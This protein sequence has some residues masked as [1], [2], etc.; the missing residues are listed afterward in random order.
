MTFLRLSMLSALLSP[1][2]DEDDLI[3]EATPEAAQPD[4]IDER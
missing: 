2:L 4:M 3:E 1:L